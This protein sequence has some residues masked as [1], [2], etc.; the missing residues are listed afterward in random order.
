MTARGTVA[1]LAVGVAAPRHHHARI[2]RHG[3]PTAEHAGPR[4]SQHDRRRRARAHASPYCT[5]TSPT[6]RLDTFS[7]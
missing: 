2:R 3:A 5:H 1:E 7:L 4:R 6:S